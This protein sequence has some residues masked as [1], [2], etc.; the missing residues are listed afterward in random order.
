MM[1][2]NLT[3][4]TILEVFTEEIQDSAAAAS[5]ILSTTAGDYSFVRCCRTSAKR[6]PK[7]GS[8]VA[9]RCAL[10]RT[11]CGCTRICSA[12][13]VATARSW[14]TRCSRCTLNTWVCY[15]L[16]EGKEMLREAIAKCAEEHVFAGSMRR[17]RTAAN[18]DVDELLNLMPHLAHFR[19]AGMGEFIAPDSGTVRQR[20]RPHAIR[21]HERGNLPG[22]RYARSGGSLATGRA[23]RRHRRS[24]APAAS[25]ECARPAASSDRTPPGVNWRQP[26]RPVAPFRA[27]IPACRCPCCGRR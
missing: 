6:G 11:S 26:I 18:T 12:R 4:G 20:R 9:W 15:T 19:E 14:R 13:C 7:I 22:P 17:L 23:G 2:D 10:P 21:A 1:S 5:R 27:A 3:T 16:E 24:L 25:L 8:K